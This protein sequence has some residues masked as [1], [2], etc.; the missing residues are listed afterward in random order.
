[1][2]SPTL[3]TGCYPTQNME[4]ALRNRRPN[5]L[6]GARGSRVRRQDKA[7]SDKA[8]SANIITGFDRCCLAASTRPGER[9][10]RNKLHVIV[11]FPL[12]VIVPFPLH[13]TE[14][15]FHAVSDGV[16]DHV[17]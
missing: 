4:S 8:F 11:P 14:P 10:L 17:R 12:H 7:F 3:A 5:S 2:R 1:M 15:G 13:V 16:N 9:D 6:S